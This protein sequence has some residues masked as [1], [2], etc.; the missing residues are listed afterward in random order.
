MDFDIAV[1]VHASPAAIWRVL[2]DVERWPE[3]SASFESIRRLDA[4]P[5]VV[6]SRARIKQPGMPA[7]TWTVTDLRLESGFSWES[8]APGVITIGT[9]E[10]R[11]SADRAVRVVL[12]IRQRGPLAGLVALLA[13]RTIRRY[14]QMESTGLKRR[15]EAQ[16]E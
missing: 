12:G 13:E 2:L 10:L 16:P 5:F 9:H 4:G 1:D 11:K 15:A 7:A 8:N 14:V 3:W 6:G